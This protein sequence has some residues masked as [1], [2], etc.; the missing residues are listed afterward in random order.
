MHT[1][2]W[3]L[4]RNHRSRRSEKCGWQLQL[5]AIK[6]QSQLPGHPPGILCLSEGEFASLCPQWE[7][8]SPFPSSWR[9]ERRAAASAQPGSRTAAFMHTTSRNGEF[10]L[11]MLR[12]YFFL[13]LGYF[14]TVCVKQ[15]P[16]HLLEK[17]IWILELVA[18]RSSWQESND[19]GRIE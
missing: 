15:S 12:C 8:R 9:T 2:E 18:I 7:C 10:I 4:F 3:Q 1:L 19:T 13:S 11:K 6:A 5:M 14:L 17:E 16:V